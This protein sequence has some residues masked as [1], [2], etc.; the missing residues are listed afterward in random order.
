VDGVPM[1][2]VHIQYVPQTEIAEGRERY[3]NRFFVH[4]REGGKFSLSTYVDGDGIPYGK[5]VLE[6]KWFEQRL[7]GE[8]DKFGGK[9]SDPDS[10]LLMKITVEK[11]P[12]IDLG[13][14]KL[15]T[16]SKE[17]IHDD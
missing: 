11:G 3:I 8:F 2:G 14:V 15:T 1:P 16:L 10:P 7:S 13:E 5:Y 6:F 9:Y 12:D 4:S 17:A